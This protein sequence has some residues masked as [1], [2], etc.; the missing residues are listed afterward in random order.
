MRGGQLGC[1]AL[2][3]AWVPPAPLPR[4]HALPPTA[5]HC[6][7][8]HAS[9]ASPVAAHLQANSACGDCR[10]G[11]DHHGQQQAE[12]TTGQGRAREGRTQGHR[13]GGCN[14]H[15]IG[16]VQGCVLPACMEADMGLLGGGGDAW[17]R[18]AGTGQRLLARGALSTQGTCMPMH[19]R[20]RHQHGAGAAKPCPLRRTGALTQCRSCRGAAATLPAAGPCGP[21]RCAARLPPPTGG[22]WPL[23]RHPTGSLR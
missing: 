4:S 22:R 8:I 13:Q 14:D 7:A 10:P 17:Q 20:L 21:A 3:R 6:A 11:Q 2:P 18:G 15:D 23:R 5:W 19:W 1:G 9:L 16:S 12:G